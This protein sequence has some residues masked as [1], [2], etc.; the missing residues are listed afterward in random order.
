MFKDMDINSWILFLK[1]QRDLKLGS[2]VIRYL[3]KEFKYYYFVEKHNR[4][5]D[6]ISYQF[7]L[8]WWLN[9]IT[10]F[11]DKVPLK[12]EVCGA[13]FN[14]RINKHLEGHQ[15]LNCLN[16]EK[17]LTYQEFIVRANKIHNNRYTYPF[18]E[19]WWGQHYK[20][21]HTKISIICPQHGLFYQSVKNHLHKEQFG[22]IYCK[23]S[24]GELKIKHFLD[25][26]NINYTHQYKV[27]IDNKSY[28]F[29]FYL[30]DY[31]VLIEY[32]GEQHFKP[33]NNFGGKE[34]LE[35]IQKRDK[36]KNNYAKAN[37]INLIRIP[38]YKFDE[39]ESILTNLI[40]GDK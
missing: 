33:N 39:I 38:Y 29:D 3:S 26:H 30:P 16:I 24:K 6:T 32:D 20:G 37:K 5:Y 19:I 2:N 27:L 13:I 25:R 22:C 36:I 35:N 17:K 40:K 9:N 23:L 11:K 28:Y 4:L 10:S 15:C 1:N 12:C 34:E 7:D 18:N 31:N 8:D 21:V 14:R